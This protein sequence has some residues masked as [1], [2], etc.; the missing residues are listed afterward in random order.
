[1]QTVVRHSETFQQVE[2]LI[3]KG[4]D[5]QIIFFAP[6]LHDNQISR[7]MQNLHG[8]LMKDDE[9]TNRHFQDL[10]TIS[11]ILLSCDP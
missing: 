4:M 3:N 8:S 10:R 5:P 11:E 1:M 2:E 7:V 9:K 6:E